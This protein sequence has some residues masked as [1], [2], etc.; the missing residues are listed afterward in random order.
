MAA[1]RKICV[2]AKRNPAGCERTGVSRGAI[3]LFTLIVLA[4]PNW[5]RAASSGYEEK[6]A[7][8]KGQYLFHAFLNEKTLEEKLDEYP[9]PQQDGPPATAIRD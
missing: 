1:Q 4:A 6:P 5:M 9:S 8:G 7:T 3:F 2:F